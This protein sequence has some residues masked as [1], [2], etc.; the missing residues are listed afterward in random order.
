MGTPPAGSSN[1]YCARSRCPAAADSVCEGGAPRGVWRILS[2]PRQ[3]QSSAAAATPAAKPQPYLLR[4]AFRG[5]ALREI[6]R[7]ASSTRPYRSEMIRR[8]RR[9]LAAAGQRS[10]TGAAHSALRPRRAALATAKR[11]AIAN[12]LHEEE[13]RD[14]PREPAGSLP[15]PAA[16]RNW[17]LAPVSPRMDTKRVKRR[18]NSVSASPGPRLRDRRRASS[19]RR[20]RAWRRTSRR[21]PGG[22]G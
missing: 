21:G 20:R 9:A 16:G 1:C 5:E 7:P 11:V 19:W 18:G 6:E 8:G 10:S 22:K 14:E 13:A 17:K 3:R 12:R 2:F 15:P 4:K